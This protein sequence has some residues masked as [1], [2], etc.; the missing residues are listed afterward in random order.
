MDAALMKVG[1]LAKKTGL[2]V[3]TLHYYEEIGLMSPAQ[4]SE[5]GYR[6]YGFDEVQRLQQVLSLQQLGFSLE[7]IRMLL[8]QPD[9]SM[10]HVLELHMARLEEQMKMQ[11]Q[12]YSRLKTISE[13]L[14]AKRDISIEAFI[15]TIKETTM[16]EKYY[17]PE[18]LETLK[19]RRGELG[20]EGMQQ[21]QAQWADLNN[22]FQNEMEKGTDPGDDRVQALVAQMQQLI[23]A[24]TGGD[25]GIE[26]SLGKMY[27]DEGPEKASRGSIDKTL[28]AYIGKAREIF[29]A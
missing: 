3:R 6:L 9:Y 12:L 20:E 1:T 19:Q 29:D 11:Q 14:H 26:R 7:E 23:L 10:H 16:Y 25:P 8:D 15:Q 5:K 27:Q 17:S 28:F 2:T 22:A 18:Q 21:A 4:R 13:H 24:F